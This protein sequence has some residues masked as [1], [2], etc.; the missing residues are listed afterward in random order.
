[1]NEKLTLQDLVDL[2]VQQKEITKKDAELFL[3]ELF[4]V[5]S[6][7]IYNNE[8]V[9]V[10]DLGTFKLT[11]VSRRESVDVNT[12][13]KIE[14][15]AHYRLSFQADKAL[16]DLV[17]KPFASFESILLE[18]DEDKKNIT[19]ELQEV[20]RDIVESEN[21]D[22]SEI[23][24][25][26][27][28]EFAPVLDVLEHEA[29]K[30]EVDV[31]GVD[32]GGNEKD[33]VEKEIEKESISKEESRPP[34]S[35]KRPDTVQVTPL[36]EYSYSTT[37]D[38]A[39]T[40]KD[41][42]SSI[43]D[44]VS[45]SI[46]SELSDIKDHKVIFRE[47]SSS[48]VL[49]QSSQSSI[50]SKDAELNIDASRNLLS[51]EV[52]DDISDEAEDVEADN[53]ESVGSGAYEDIPEFYSYQPSFWTRFW[54]RLPLILF[55]IIVLGGLTY[56]FLKLFDVKYDYDRFFGRKSSS[57]ALVDSV[58]E[59]PSSA[60]NNPLLLDSLAGETSR[61]LD[62]L[63]LRAKGNES[64]ELT[65]PK[66]NIP[67]VNKAESKLMDQQKYQPI[68]KETIKAGSTL[69]TLATRYY[70]Q[71]A[72]WVYIYEENKSAIEDPDNIPLGL[73]VNIPRPEKYK[74][75]G[76]DVNSISVAKEKELEIIR[77][78]RQKRFQKAFSKPNS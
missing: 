64:V 54:R 39:K 48:E 76:K 10:K 44:K 11:T 49:S 34:I 38:T 26:E 27:V 58:L 43:K 9:K 70:G 68:A 45:E 53:T 32:Q 56:A 46:P 67:N 31:T 8:S 28:E 16:K 18:D 65:S 50:A 20:Q 55:V 6:D 66:E 71:S 62:S 22:Y 29:I 51:E 7:T 1:M 37:I 25:L 24:D 77:I 63:K 59:K 41:I 75:D 5:L 23:D 4:T 47:S 35:N 61:K 30:V 60:T 52:D 15:P 36:F 21:E 40:G 17:N 13:E 19:F 14:I 12:G 2:L 72:F 57:S 33:S 42:L 78:A 74:I 73:T 69:R 3:K